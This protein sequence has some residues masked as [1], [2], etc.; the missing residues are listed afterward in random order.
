MNASTRKR[1]NITLDADLIE[2]AREMDVNLSRAAEEGIRHA[3]R[4]KW[5]E[6]NRASLE[7]WGRWAEEKG[8]PLAKYRMF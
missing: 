6:D 2:T 8:L 5:A 1:T 4:E 7:A 3:V